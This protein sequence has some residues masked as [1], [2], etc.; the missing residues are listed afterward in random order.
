MKTMNKKEGL[1]IA[2]FSIGVLA[3]ASILLHDYVQGKIIR[4]GFYDK[5][6][7]LLGAIF[8]VIGLI[9]F[10]FRRYKIY[11]KRRIFSA[12]VNFFEALLVVILIASSCGVGGLLYNYH[13]TSVAAEDEWSIGIYISS[14]H[15][16]FNFTYENVSNPVLTA[17]NVLDVQ[18]K[19]V[20]DPFL[21]Y[22]NDSYYMFFDSK[23][24][25]SFLT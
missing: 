3:L 21:I 7:I 22:E 20:A 16:P 6:G 8:T 5:A 18:A 17:D 23:I 1:C 10:I 14:S 13:Y 11:E 2:I 25:S 15:E 12:R 24:Q 9:L 4:Y 19:F